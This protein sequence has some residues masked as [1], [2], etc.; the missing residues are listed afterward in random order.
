MSASPDLRPGQ[1]WCARTPDPCTTL[2]PAEHG[3]LAGVVANRHVAPPQ[4]AGFADAQA[5][6]I[7]QPEAP[8]CG[9]GVR[10]RA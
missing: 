6:E 5:A 2:A 8:C 3:D 10:G 9:R 4:P 1:G 7:E